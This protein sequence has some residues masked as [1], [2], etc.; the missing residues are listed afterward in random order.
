[1]GLPKNMLYRDRLIALAANGP[2]GGRIEF[3]DTTDDLT[4]DYAQAVAA[5]NFSASES[6][7]MTCLEASAAGLPV[8]ATRCGGPEEII[9]HGE[10]GFLVAVGD[11]DAM[12][13]RI[14]WLLDHPV[15]AAAMGAAG[16]T[17]VQTRFSPIE[18]R[19][20]FSGLYGLERHL[21]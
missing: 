4:A 10:T 11:I 20:A 7:S 17:L 5:L 14:A 9:A 1:M 15:E 6:F 21:S 2:A 8:I 19:A 13:T 12:A 16:R 18:A 3:R